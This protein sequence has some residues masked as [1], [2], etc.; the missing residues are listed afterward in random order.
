VK[1]HVQP[2]DI[3][4]PSIPHVFEYYT[5][6]QGNYYINTLFAKKVTYDSTFPEP[7]LEINSVA[8]L[9]SVI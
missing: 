8:I 3:I 2:G 1:N 9:Q 5:G 7:H 4:I 6:I